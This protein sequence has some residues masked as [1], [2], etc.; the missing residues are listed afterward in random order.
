MELNYKF[1]DKYKLV[2][3][4]NDMKIKNNNNK[5]NQMSLTYIYYTY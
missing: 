3:P 5:I 1:K 4:I 2:Q